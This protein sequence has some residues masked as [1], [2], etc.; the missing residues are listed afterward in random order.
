M[1]KN[2]EKGITLVVLVITIIILLILAGISIS[3]L[4]NQGLFKNA[5]EIQL[6]NKRAQISEYLKLKLINEQI[7]NPFGSAKEIIMETRNNIIE[8]IN[9]LKKI[10]KEIYINEINEEEKNGYFY[11]E[12]DK[13]LYKVDLNGANYIGN[14]ENDTNCP[15]FTVNATNGKIAQDGTGTNG[16]ISFENVVEKESG[17]AGYYIGQDNPNTK[18]VFYGNTKSI[19]VN[20]S[21]IW[22]LAIK[23]NA[24]NISEIQSV[25]YYKLDLNA[26]GATNCNS[27]TTYIKEETLINLPTGL[28]KDKYKAD[29]WTGDVSTINIKQNINLTP[30][31]EKLTFVGNIVGVKQTYGES[32]YIQGPN[33]KEYGAH[34]IS[35][36]FTEDGNFLII[37]ISTANLQRKIYL[38][39]NL[40]AS[41]T[42]IYKKMT[43]GDTVKMYTYANAG[44]GQTFSSQLLIYQLTTE[45]VL[46]EDK[47]NWDEI[48]WKE[49]TKINGMTTVY[50]PSTAYIYNSGSKTQQYQ[51][52]ENG[53][54]MI[55]PTSTC[56]LSKILYINGEKVSYGT[57]IKVLHTGDI[58]KH[59]GFGNTDKKQTFTVTTRIYKFEFN[60]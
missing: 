4:T 35:Y 11:V 30:N 51:I 57:Q 22:Y 27:S 41:F 18:K 31:W 54:Y 52:T 38:N 49:V 13:D 56:N 32:P 8:N 59:Y 53:L 36:T 50:S 33:Y 45:E 43:S 5:K 44:N 23:D 60:E 12:V 34:T 58:V 21:G 42:S 16:T 20:N 6:E 7:N 14:L 55:V 24:G 10:G 29:T 9:E 3:A 25:T 47:E 37:P 19:T 15:T 40:Q 39:D 48:Q 1:L 46:E 2:R 17:I 26:D 28:K